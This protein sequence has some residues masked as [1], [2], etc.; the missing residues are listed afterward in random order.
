MTKKGPL[1]KAEE[2]YVKHHYKNQD[3]KTIAKDLD[4]P[5]ATIRRSVEK[6][7][8]EEPTESPTV[9]NQMARQEGIVIMTETASSISDEA[10]LSK[11][12]SRPSCIAPIRQ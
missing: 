8:Q 10:S 4:R 5:I 1:G 7:R 9:G 2:F 3:E 11:S 6:H 12:K